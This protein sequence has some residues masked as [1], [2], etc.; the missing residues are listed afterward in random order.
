[1]HLLELR[2]NRLFRRS[3]SR[4]L[5]L[6]RVLLY[7]SGYNVG[8][9][10]ACSSRQH[11]EPDYGGE[12]RC[13]DS[14]CGRTDKSDG[15]QEKVDGGNY[16][17]DSSP[18]RDAREPSRHSQHQPVVPTILRS[19][20]MCAYPQRSLMMK[21]TRPSIRDTAAFACLTMFSATP[22]TVLSQGL[23]VIPAAPKTDRS[24]LMALDGPPLMPT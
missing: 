14:L 19:T 8:P 2:P 23:D 24:V 17:D 15:C 1:M 21:F 22:S 16:Q 6:V 9:D 18:D 5:R 3:G 11:D 7:D 10:Q 4:L 13:N 20:C 12:K